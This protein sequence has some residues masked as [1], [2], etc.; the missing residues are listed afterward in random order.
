MKSTIQERL[1]WWVGVPALAVVLVAL[2]G[3]QYRWSDEVSV[4]TRAQMQSGLQV[5]MMGFRLDL[6][7]ELDAACLELRPKANQSGK[8]QP[9]ELSGQFQHWQQTAAHPSLVAQLYVWQN[10]GGSSP[11]LALDPNK[12]Q[13]EPVPW[14][15]T[16]EPLRQH[17]ESMS[18]QVIMRAP[19]HANRARGQGP[20][21]SQDPFLPWFVDQSIPALVYPWRN[22]AASPESKLA[23]PVTWIIVQLNPATLEKEVFPELAQKY[24]RGDYRVAVLAGSSDRVLYSSAAG[25]G[26]AKEGSYDAG[27]NL[28]GPP[29][30]RGDPLRAPNE[31]FGIGGRVSS[32][33]RM[34]PPQPSSQTDDRRVQALDRPVRLEPFLY[35]SEQGV[36]QIV[37][38]HQRGS[39]EAVVAA[40]RRRHLIASFGV[41]VMLAVTMTMV[42]IATQRARRLAGAQM[43]FVAGVSHELRTPLAV[44]SSA[45]ENIA[46]GVVSDPQQ[47]ARYSAT[48][49]KQT[50]QLTQLIEQVLFFAST[51]QKMGQYNLRPI[52]VNLVIDAALENTASMVA[53]AGVEIERRIEPALPEVAA[54]FSALSQCLQNLITNAVKY[55]GDKHWLGIRATAYREA[56]EVRGVEITVEDRGIGISAQ[57]IKHIFEPF[58]RSPQVAGSNVHGTGLGLPLA[59]TVIE[60]MNGSLTVESEP[61]R[62]SAFTVH[63][64]LASSLRAPEHRSAAEPISGETAG[65]YPS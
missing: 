5:S 30:R 31:L 64:P 63:L 54:D 3:L 9:A 65:S 40:M 23:A 47:L 22:H 24:F 13:L 39:V 17:L 11:L 53:A 62:G 27:L 18:A 21:H 8:L 46:H 60:A 50:R 15:S 59:R 44:I 57:E 10:S 38:K 25:F 58:Y 51:Q 48:I 37:V 61:G 56:G 28:F 14:P 6:A 33:P 12:T 55:G 35:S 20:R 4:A 41:L 1:F 45:A 34:R 43:S 36:W 32:P 7:R 52:D 26:G 2:G 16:F 49:L 42:L 19:R 29:F